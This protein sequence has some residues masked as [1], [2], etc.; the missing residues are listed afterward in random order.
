MQKTRQAWIQTA[1]DI[2]PEH[3]HVNNRKETATQVGVKSLLDQRKTEKIS[4]NTNSS[5]HEDTNNKGS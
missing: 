5:S 2:T 1:A 3:H 4:Q